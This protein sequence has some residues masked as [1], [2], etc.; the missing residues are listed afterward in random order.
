MGSLLKEDIRMM[1]TMVRLLVLLVGLGAIPTGRLLADPG[2]IVQTSGTVNTLR[3]VYLVDANVGIV[4]GDSGTILRTE[5]GGAT[6]VSQTSGTSSTLRGVSF[7]NA[8]T[9]T[10]VGD[11][12]VILRTTNAGATW[13]RQQSGA[14]FPFWSVVTP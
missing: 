11:T 13:V 12:G 10:I 6:W 8:T 5:D 3:G 4:V 14:L 7:V 9:G 2:W 1:K